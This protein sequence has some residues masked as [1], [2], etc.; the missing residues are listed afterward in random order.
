MKSVAKAT[1]RFDHMNGTSAPRREIVSLSASILVHFFDAMEFAR[2]LFIF[3]VACDALHDAAQS[4]GQ[5]RRRRRMAG[6][7]RNP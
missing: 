2:M 6:R 5:F 4:T 1:R 7:V 3:S